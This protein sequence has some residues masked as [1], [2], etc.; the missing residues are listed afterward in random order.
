MAA[1]NEQRYYDT[2]KRI[3]AY[4]SPERLR[5]ASEKHWGL[6]Y[7]EALQYSYENIQQEAKN[8]TKGKRRPK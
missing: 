4:Q 6:P 8:A 5:R 1:S 7:E 2:L 3:A